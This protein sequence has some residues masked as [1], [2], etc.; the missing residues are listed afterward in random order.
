[1]SI[2][3]VHRIDP[4]A[5]MSRAVIHGS[6]VYLSGH[7]AGNTGGG[8]AEQTREILAKIEEVLAQAGSDKSLILSA[9][10]WLA[11]ISTFEEMNEVW[12]AWVVPGQ[13]PARATVEAKLAGRDYKVEVSV[14]AATMSSS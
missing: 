11:D 12:D 14:I 13:P 3:N 6:T 8:V 7:V 10:I 4:T 5:R 2:K 9:S 1:M